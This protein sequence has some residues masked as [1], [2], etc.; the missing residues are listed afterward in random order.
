ML[1]GKITSNVP[2]DKIVA[3]WR[4]EFPPLTPPEE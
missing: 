3:K 1:N 2:K 4:G